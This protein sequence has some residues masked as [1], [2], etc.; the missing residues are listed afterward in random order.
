MKNCW[1]VYFSV[2]FWSS[3]S[4][5]LL[6]PLLNNHSLL[7]PLII[8]LSLPVLLIYPVSTVAFHILFPLRFIGHLQ[9]FRWLDIDWDSKWLLPCF[10]TTQVS[11]PKA[12]KPSKMIILK[13]DS[14]VSSTVKSTLFTQL[15]EYQ[16]TL[17]Q[18]TWFSRWCYATPECQ[19]FLWFC[20]F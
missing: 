7:P 5:F 12:R 10:F 14:N 1:A 20:I 2:F 4:H 8:L 18:N 11:W 17:L 16:A 6:L 3:N 13:I 9:W 19:D 15:S